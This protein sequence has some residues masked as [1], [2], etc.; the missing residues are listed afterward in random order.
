MKATNSCYPEN[1]RDRCEQEE[2]T[3]PEGQAKAATVPLGLNVLVQ[4]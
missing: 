2:L 4:K 1:G 3:A